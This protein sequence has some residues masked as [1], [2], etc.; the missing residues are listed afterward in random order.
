MKKFVFL[1][2]RRTSEEM[3]ETEE[4]QRVS[5]KVEKGLAAI[6]EE[7]QRMRIATKAQVDSLAIDREARAVRYRPQSK[8]GSRSWRL[9][10]RVCCV[11]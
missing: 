1:R 8:S 7:L 4:Y 11:R 2:S 10:A 5:R 3:G 6:Q 9:K